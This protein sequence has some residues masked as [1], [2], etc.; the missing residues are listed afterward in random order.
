MTTGQAATAHFY[1]VIPAGGS[2]KRLWPV[3]RSH[4]PKFVQPFAGTGCSLLRD[5]VNRV[6]DLAPAEQTFVVTGGSLAPL[7]ARE[8]PTLPAGNIL[9]E[10]APRDSAPAISL[11]AAVIAELDPDA[12][13]GSFAADHVIK[14]PESFRST[15][16]RAVDCAQRGYLTTVGIT[17][18]HPETGYGYIRVGG[19]LSDAP[20]SLVEEF[21]EKPPHDVAVEYLNSGRYLWNA[22]FFVWRVDVFLDQLRRRHPEFHDAM[23]RIAGA[24]HTDDRD[25]VLARIWPTLPK[26]AIEY[27]LME[28]AAHDGVVATVPGEFGWSDV[29][30]Y[31]ALGEIHD[32]DGQGNVVVSAVPAVHDSTRNA[33]LCAAP[34]TAAAPD[35]AGSTRPGPAV[36]AEDGGT[37]GTVVAVEDGTTTTV[38]PVGGE[39]AAGRAPTVRL[40]DSE[41]LVV[42]SEGRRMIA[43]VGVHDMVVVD[44]SDVLLVCDR[45]RAQDVKKVVE[46]LEAD[47]LVDYL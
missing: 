27:L 42:V 13:M 47:G 24:W 4:F 35:P 12:V 16:R 5:T 18:D 19:D 36:P 8:A 30:D 2:G 45:S 37:P 7:I 21:V 6:A 43:V 39:D 33:D 22:S 46:G 34:A 14:D 11:A 26:I 31:H 25:E 3:S 29:G 9:V 32:S 17:P 1:P 15:V 44:T 20:G 41:R 10:P 38:V 23:R 28:P 40:S